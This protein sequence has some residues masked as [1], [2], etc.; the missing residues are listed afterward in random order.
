MSTDQAPAETD[1]SGRITPELWW[2][3]G[4]MALGGFAS[5]LDST[6][7]NVAVGPLARNFDAE[8][9]TVQ[10][11]VTGYLLALSVSI[12]L[13]G[14][15][16]ARFGAK[17][18]LIFSQVVF[19]V[20]SLLAGLAWSAPSLIAF[21]LLQGIGGGLLVPIGQA[22]LAQAAGP[23]R[24]GR[25]MGIVSIPAMFAPLIAPSLGGVMVD[26]LSWRW[27]FF[28]NVPLC[29]IT[30]V[31]VL[32]KVRNV[33]EPSKDA[34][35]DVLGMVLLMPGLAALLYGLSEAGSAG[36]FGDGKTV[37]GL[38]IG[39]AFL[40]AFA[41]RALRTRLEPLVDLRLFRR[42]GFRNGT[43]ANMLLS[44]AMYGVM[45]PLPLYFQLVHGAS[46]LESA[47]LLLPQSLGF[48]AGVVMMNQLT[49]MLG[50]RNL[51][52]LGI[53]LAVLGTIP[54]ALIDADPNAVVLGLA[55]VVRG[56]GLGASMLPTM[57]VAFGSVPKELAPSATSAFN[58]FQRVSASLG[59]AVL[60]VVLQQQIED[61]LP[62]GVGSVVQVLPGSDVAKD[63]ATSFGPPFWWAL[64]IT[65]LAVLPS[66]FL[67][68][69]EPA[70]VQAPDAAPSR[71]GESAL[72]PG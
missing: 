3:S 16:A 62:T 65:A 52:L 19:L 34:K 21:R 6:I 44:M 69:R 2:L 42:S 23:K 22:L 50:V 10:W 70:P 35:L 26:Y 66:L 40:A 37:G 4:I 46:V 15:S 31:L 54:Y 36:G 13:S 11:V 30:V 71:E 8:I 14:W 7:V 24:L 55:M 57:T 41:V 56:F 33:V 60:A 18:M 39:V 20:G 67:P 47:L 51:T 38:V 43:L 25:L 1:D 32:L 49:A 48:F 68:G 64:V 72:K 28:I 5:L 53:L 29:L 12:P 61:R 27:L 17:Q 59:T 45:I 9:S 63:L 58:V